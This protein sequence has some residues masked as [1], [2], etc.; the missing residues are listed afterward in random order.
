MAVT[1]ATGSV[2]ETYNYTPYGELIDSEYREDI[3]FLYNGQYGVTT[4]SN[5]LYYMRA[6]YYN[7]EIKRFINQDV[8]LGVLERVSSLNRYS[9]VEG[10]P[11]SYLDPFGL[12][13]IAYYTQIRRDLQWASVAI[14]SVQ[15]IVAGAMVVFPE[16]IPLGIEIE[17]S[18]QM[19]S[20]LVTVMDTF[21]LDM[22][23]SNVSYEEEKKYEA[24]LWWNFAS[25]LT[26][27]YI[28]KRLEPTTDKG[29]PE[30][31]SSIMAWMD[32]IMKN[33]LF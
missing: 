14:V 24:Q 9:Y 4:D 3:P 26:Q 1:D 20:L 23:C 25:T 18:L 12:E 30:V 32:G 11:I 10:N 7:V 29:F 2:I 22:L 21:A 8:L 5:G 17:Q 31:F 33:G 28:G 13:K 15:L 6:R 27:T 16:F 19:I